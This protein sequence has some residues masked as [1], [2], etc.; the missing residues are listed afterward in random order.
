MPDETLKPPPIPHVVDIETGGE[1]RQLSSTLEPAEFFKATQ[2]DFSQHPCFGLHRNSPI[3]QIEVFHN[4]QFLPG[5]GSVRPTPGFNH[6][7]SFSQETGAW[8]RSLSS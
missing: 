8:G 7:S 5:F 4:K 2:Q 6:P 3:L 1:I